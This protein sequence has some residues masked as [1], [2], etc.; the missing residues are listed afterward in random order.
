MPEMPII[1]Q[2][3]LNTKIISRIRPQVLPHKH[4]SIAVVKHLILTMILRRRPDSQVRQTGCVR[5]IVD[6]VPEVLVSGE[7]GGLIEFAAD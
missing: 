5:V 6:G 7:L 3:Y 1:K 4:I 2:T